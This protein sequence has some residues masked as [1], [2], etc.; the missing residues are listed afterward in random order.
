MTIAPA[1]LFLL[2]LATAA[3][4]GEAEAGPG[5]VVELFEDDTPLVKHI[6]AADRGAQI[7]RHAGDAFSGVF[8]LRVTPLQRYHPI[9]P[10]WNYP[11]VEKPGKGQYRYLRFAWKSVGGRGIMLQLSERGNWEGRRYVAGVNSVGWA[12]RQVAAQAPKEWTLVTRDLFA[13]FGPMTL[14]GMAFTPMDGT[15]GLYDHIYLARSL[16]DLDRMDAP[17]LRKK[18]QEELSPEKL[19]ALWRDLAASDLA[20]AYAAQWTWVAAGKQAVPFF[21]ERL[22]TK[23]LAERQERVAGLLKDLDDDRFVTREKATTA[24]RKMGPAIELTLRKALEQ[25]A[26]LEAR[27]RMG[28]L[29]EAIE[30]GEAT[31]PPEDLR[32]LRAVRVLELI[33][34]PDARQALNDLVERAPD[35]DAG[36]EA[37]LAVQR[38]KERQQKTR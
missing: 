11:I 20:T 32:L 21:R 25:P 27:R 4:A 3:R 23:M 13:D 26:S 38:L 18:P 24:L 1:F 17:L 36:Q 8:C 33:G 10:G 15:A 35:S 30:R 31:R 19:K 16:E 14:T 29:L 2:G 37:R 12:A 6:T 9:I 22:P 28:V 34:T 5:P 7:E